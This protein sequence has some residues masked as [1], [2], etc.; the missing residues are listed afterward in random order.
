MDTIDQYSHA[1][2]QTLDE[3]KDELITQMRA[4]IEEK[5]R[6]IENQHLNIQTQEHHIR[7]TA[8]PLD[9]CNKFLTLFRFDGG[10]K[11]SANSSHLRKNFLKRFLF[12]ASMNYKQDFK[13]DAGSYEFQNFDNDAE[14]LQIIRNMNHKSEIDGNQV[15][16]E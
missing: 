5:D 16:P 1:T 14:I 6:I 4:T 7:E 15:V 10:F 12:S 9:N 11:I 8:V 2:N 3:T 13:R